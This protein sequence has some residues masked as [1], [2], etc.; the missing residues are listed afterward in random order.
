MRLLRAH[1]RRHLLTFPF[2]RQEVY[3]YRRQERSAS[4]FIT[5][6]RERGGGGAAGGSA[7]AAEADVVNVPAAPGLMHRIFSLFTGT[8]GTGDVEVAPPAPRVHLPLTAS[9][10]PL[11]LTMPPSTAIVSPKA[12]SAA[13]PRKLARVEDGVSFAEFM[14]SRKRVNTGGPGRSAAPVQRHLSRDEV[15]HA[16]TSGLSA[17]RSAYAY[18]YGFECTSGNLAWL[19]RKVEEAVDNDNEDE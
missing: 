4:R 15:E 14:A 5:A 10:P 12:A 11:L 7:D 17:L 3:D 19:R 16:L 2:S 18:A 9:S 13:K 6:F 8:G 1:P